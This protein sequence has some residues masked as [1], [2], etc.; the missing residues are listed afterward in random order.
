MDW[1]PVPAWSHKPLDA[2]SNPVPATTFSLQRCT[3]TV[4]G[5][6]RESEH[7]VQFRAALPIMRTQVWSNGG[8]TQSA[9]IAALIVQGRLPKPDLVVIAD[10]E[11][12]R[13]NVW[14]YLDEIIRP[15]LA[16]VNVEVHRIKKSEFTTEDVWQER[17]NTELPRVNLPVFVDTASSGGGKLTTVC[18]REWKQVVIRRWLRSIGVEQCDS[19]IGM[20]LDEVSRVRFSGL[21]WYQHRYPLIFDVPLRR[22]ECIRLV[23]E[24]MKWPEPPKS[25]CWMC[26][27]RDDSSWL[28]MKTNAPGEFALAVE[29]EREMRERRKDFFLHRSLTPLDQV[30]FSTS[31]LTMIDSGC[32][33]GYC[34]A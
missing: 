18:S 7:P 3:W 26:P 17:E 20:S 5:G 21:Q 1:S 16:T 9:A 23:I 30:N 11:R 27:N 34:F 25:A 29:F 6:L 31:Q 4:D 10:T 13:S 33:T 22:G 8:G 12:E 2:G 19:W 28:D 14:T 24:Q 32:E 15:A